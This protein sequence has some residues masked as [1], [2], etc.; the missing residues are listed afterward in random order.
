[1]PIKEWPRI[2]QLLDAVLDLPPSQRSDYLD[3]H[4]AEDLR[5]EVDALL[6]AEDEVE[7]FIERPVAELLSRWIA[8]D[9][10][11]QR[12][13]VFGLQ[14][15]LGQ[16]GMGMVYLARRDD[17]VFD[18]RVA[19]KVLKR[20]GAG[21]TIR[22]FHQERQILADLVHENVARILDGGST[23]DGLPYLVMEYVEGLPIDQYCKKNELDQTEILELFHQVAMAVH[24]AHQRLI[25]HCDLKPGNILVTAD[26]ISKLLDFGIAQIARDEEAA[27]AAT[28]GPGGFLGTPEYSSPEQKHGGRVSTASDVYALGALLDR[29]LRICGRQADDD[30]AL[31]LAKATRDEPRE[32]YPSAIELAQD[33]RR[34]LE[35]RPVT[36][37]RQAPLYLLR[38]FMRRNM[39]AVAF[40]LVA[41]LM[42]FIYLEALRRQLEQAEASRDWTLLVADTLLESSEGRLDPGRARAIA[43]K[44]QSIELDPDPAERSLFF[45]RLGRVFLRNKLLDEAQHLVQEALLIR[46]ETG[47]DPIAIA[48]S[49]NNLG[50][51][52]LEKDDIEKGISLIESAIEKFRQ[53]GN[54]EP[55]TE[56]RMLSNLATGLQKLNRLEDAEKI[57]RQVLAHRELHLG[58]EDEDYV[59]AMNKLARALLEQNKTEEAGLLMTEGL[60]LRRKLWGYDHPKVAVALVNYAIFLD[61]QGDF[62]KA[63]AHHRQALRIRRGHYE[64]GH[65]STALSRNALAFSLLGLGHRAAADEAHTLLKRALAD[66]QAAYGEQHRNTLTIR[67][68]LA[69]ALLAQDR[70]EDAEV[71]IRTMLQHAAEVWKNE[72]PWRMAD[73]RSVLGSCLAGQE[74]YSEAEELLVEGFRTLRGKLGSKSRYTREAQERLEEFF[75]KTGTPEKVL[76]YVE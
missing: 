62:E 30:L 40:T 10:E 69:V 31:I 71:Q 12:V 38:R 35:H 74:R 39:T 22:R 1:M 52:H 72:D 23:A 18:Q 55:K 37:R 8:E 27:E 49:L 28:A 19:L 20:L 15:L 32:R 46:E 24:F 34:Y 6:A 60:K 21:D 3:R 61:T 29:L 66:Y 44:V 57:F 68:N 51:V 43:E 2:K 16:G 53:A 9:R 59:I 54:G 45:D 17:G 7:T 67:R 36:A 56:L 64:D 13:G 11:G 73:A 4:C 58:K 5:A 47:A 14:R 75:Q 25:I 76:R 42:L 33:L 41:V 48:E 50:L 63:I 70:P 65:P 26:G